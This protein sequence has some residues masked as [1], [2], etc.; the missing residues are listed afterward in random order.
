MI[1]SKVTNHTL[2]NAAGRIDVSVGVSYSANIQKAH[3]L[4]LEAACQYPGTLSD[5]EP[6]CFLTNFGDSSVDF[7]LHFWVSDVKKGRFLPKSEVLFSIWKKFKD[8]NI[9]IPF[10]QRDLHLKT[11]KDHFEF[12]EKK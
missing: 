3:E 8:N 2:S 6:N 5:P 11:V 4:I 1:T 12:V 7:L 9:E 10:P